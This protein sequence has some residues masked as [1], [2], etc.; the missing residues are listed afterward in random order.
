MKEH[1]EDRVTVLEMRE[2]GTGA[3]D[4]GPVSS[5]DLLSLIERNMTLI[6]TK[7]RIFD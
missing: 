3:E 2:V 6:G 1:G 5:L 7:S 4:G